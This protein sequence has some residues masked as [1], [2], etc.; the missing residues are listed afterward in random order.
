MVAANKSYAI[1][2]SHLSPAETKK[3]AQ[4]FKTFV[5]KREA[6]ARDAALGAVPDIAASKLLVQVSGYGNVAPY[7]RAAP[8][9]KPLVD[10]LGK[11]SFAL[12]GA[13]IGL[14]LQA[15]EDSQRS[16]LSGA[17]K[18]G[19]TSVAL[20]GGAIPPLGLLL[21]GLSLA[22]PD[23]YDRITAE[24]FSDQDPVVQW[25]AGVIVNVGGKSFQQWSAQPS[26][27]DFF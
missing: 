18:L 15:Y 21:L 3:L 19:R 5:Q 2:V 1:R 6:P 12:F 24:A 17:Q 25:F 26:W 23:Q 11:E 7:V 10:A 16:D 4:T 22:Y 8:G 27:I 9:A 14:G 13:L 20:L